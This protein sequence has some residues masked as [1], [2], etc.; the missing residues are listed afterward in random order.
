MGD[1][2]EV[3]EVGWEAIRT[4]C[5][6][7]AAVEGLRSCWGEGERFNEADWMVEAISMGNDDAIVH[8][9]FV[10]RETKNGVGW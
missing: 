3:G 2:G 10:A 9:M 7:E 4:G 6:V 8:R 1:W 5:L